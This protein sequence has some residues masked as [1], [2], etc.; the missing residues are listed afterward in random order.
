M[1]ENIPQTSCPEYSHTIVSSG[2]VF[3]EAVPNLSLHLRPWT[4]I[5]IILKIDIMKISM[6]EIL[7]DIKPQIVLQRKFNYSWRTPTEML[8]DSYSNIPKETFW[9]VNGFPPLINDACERWSTREVS[10]TNVLHGL[11]NFITHQSS[12]PSS[13][14]FE[15]Y[16][17]YLSGIIRPIE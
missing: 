2:S 10:P 1:L 9:K 7:V 14:F 16:K 6:A 17:I 3:F 12:L 15:F 11:S 4:L 5:S 8:V 13:N